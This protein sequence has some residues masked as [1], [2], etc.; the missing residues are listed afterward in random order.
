[1][2]PE[3]T[4]PT[5]RSF[6]AGAIAALMTTAAD[7]AH[8]SPATARAFITDL[9]NETVSILQSHQP[10]AE[11]AF[12]LENLFRRAFDFRAI[13]RFV[14]GRYWNTANPQQREEYLRAF[15]DY[16]TKSYADRLADEQVTG[17][18]ITS[19]RDLGQNEYLV[20]TQ[21][22]RP[23]GAALNYGWR[24]RQTSGGPRIVDIIVE[25][26]SLLVTHRSDFT[27]VAQREGIEGLTQSLRTKAG[28]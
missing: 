7:R 25:N 13:G 22:G 10:S 28:R 12:R 1:M 4:V 18:E 23:T 24:V 27:S 2:K 20:Q 15:T 26:V 9:G 21:I 14:L 3:D 5:R 16:V 11:R 19:V 6:L 8:A 17:F